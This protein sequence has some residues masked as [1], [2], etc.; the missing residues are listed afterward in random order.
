MT[1][2][3]VSEF[4]RISAIRAARKSEMA[5]R[6]EKRESIATAETGM[7]ILVCGVA[8]CQSGGSMEVYR[9]LE[10]KIKAQHLEESIKLVSTGCMGLCAQGPLMVTYPDRVM[11][12]HVQPEDV[13][14]IESFM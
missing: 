12:T 1:S 6:F 8:G 14:E 7:H 3:M 9:L 10:E 13:E 2:N 4:R 5:P 11:Y